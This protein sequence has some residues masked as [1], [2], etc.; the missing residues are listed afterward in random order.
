MGPVMQELQSRLNDL[1]TTYTDA[2]D[3]ARDSL[4]TQ[5]GLFDELSIKCELS[6]Q[7][8]IESLQSQQ[9][10][11]DNYAENLRTA[12]HWGIDEGLLKSLSDGSVESMQYLQAI[13]DGGE[14]AIDDLNAAFAKSEQ[15]K[16]NLSDELA[17]AATG[18]REQYDEMK[19]DAKEAGLNIVDG[20]VT[21][22]NSNSDRFYRAMANMAGTGAAC[23]RE[24][25]SIYSPSR[26]MADYGKYIDLG[27][28]QGVE[29]H[30]NKF[31]LAMEKLSA[32]GDASFAP[33]SSHAVYNSVESTQ[34]TQSVNL[35]GLSVYVNAGPISDP[36]QLADLLADRIQEKVASRSLLYV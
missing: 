10:A 23:F 36:D 4:D 26:L 7:D 9:V 24:Y 27:L 3:S 12:A 30:S 8:M 20:L 11:M 35:G 21:G 16:D 19:S 33:L 25:Y 28:A 1:K 13:V 34:N 6:V 22:V 5:I 31:V 32:L 17:A 18:A 29:A 2:R 15:A 14:G